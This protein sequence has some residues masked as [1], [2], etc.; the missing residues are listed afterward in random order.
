LDGSAS[1]PHLGLSLLCQK[2]N[3]ARAARKSRR[4]VMNN[5]FRLIVEMPR[6][7]LNG[8]TIP[9]TTGSKR[10]VIRYS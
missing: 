1:R 3:C 5:R 9:D 4:S 7:N 2:L 8:E 10:T 6:A